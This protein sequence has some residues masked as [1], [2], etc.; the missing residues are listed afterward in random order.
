M[1]LL[2]PVIFVFHPLPLCPT[3]TDKG[4]LAECRPHT[5]D[6]PGYLP[7][8]IERGGGDSHM[9]KAIF[10]LCVLIYKMGINNSTHLFSYY[11]L[12]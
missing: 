11:L 4:D 3:S 6:P 5:Q 1:C 2:A 7:E 8:G 12:H 10:C 9:R